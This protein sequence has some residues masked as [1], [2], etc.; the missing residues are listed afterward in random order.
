MAI[1]AT[2][3]HTWLCRALRCFVER[4]AFGAQGGAQEKRTRQTFEGF[5]TKTEK[6]P[7]TEPQGVPE[8]LETLIR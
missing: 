6:R 4:F 7:N 8:A 5:M 2:Y 1:K 3:G